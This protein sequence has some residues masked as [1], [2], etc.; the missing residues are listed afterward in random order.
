[1]KDPV[2]SFGINEQVEF[3]NK[4]FKFRKK[5]NR[6]ISNNVKEESRK[7]DPNKFLLGFRNAPQNLSL[8]TVVLNC[9]Q[10]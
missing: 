5:A 1:M 2:I 4:S 9:K 6:T 10:A 3:Y 8:K 7:H